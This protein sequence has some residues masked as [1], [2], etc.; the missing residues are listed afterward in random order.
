M[1]FSF[2]ST[3]PS[4][5]LP[6][7]TTARSTGLDDQLVVVSGGLY[8]LFAP[9]RM[10]LNRMKLTKRSVDVLFQNYRADSTETDHRIA[11]RLHGR[12]LGSIQW[13]SLVFD[14][15]AWSKGQS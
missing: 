9:N 6:H 8:S 13:W 11:S 4:F 1:K 7:H 10:G 2:G 15:S 14:R 5:L 12:R 3:D